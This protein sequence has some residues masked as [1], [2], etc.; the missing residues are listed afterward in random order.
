ML[1][2]TPADQLSTSASNLGVTSV[3]NASVADQFTAYRRL[4]NRIGVLTYKGKPA[5]SVAA[6]YA[7]DAKLD[8]PN[9]LTVVKF[10]GTESELVELLVQGNIAVSRTARSSN[11]QQGPILKDD[12]GLIV[13]TDNRFRPSSRLSGMDTRVRPPIRIK[14]VEPDYTPAS[15]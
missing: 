2:R 11:G 4:A 5:E 1:A 8:I 3:D 9:D 13:L 10:R 15:A 7:P 6:I 14:I 12:E